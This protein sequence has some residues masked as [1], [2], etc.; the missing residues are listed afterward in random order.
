M[1]ADEAA[2]STFDHMNNT[3]IPVN[4]MANGQRASKE[5]NEVRKEPNGDFQV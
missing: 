1:T 4:E 3:A 5:H 2:P